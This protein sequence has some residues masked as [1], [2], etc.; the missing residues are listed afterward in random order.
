MRNLAKIGVLGHQLDVADGG[1]VDPGTGRL[2]SIAEMQQALRLVRTGQLEP[3]STA[4]ARTTMPPAPSR[5]RTRGVEPAD[6]GQAVDAGDDDPY[7]WDPEQGSSDADQDAQDDL[8][9][10][11]E[12]NEM[13]GSAR[14]RRGRRVRDEVPA[15]PKARRHGRGSRRAARPDAGAAGTATPRPRSRSAAVRVTR[16]ILGLDRGPDPLAGPPVAD[17]QGFDVPDT[18]EVEPA[19]RRR[20]SAADDF[21]VAAAPRG[22]AAVFWRW[23][24]R[25]LVVVLLAAGVNQLF[26]K[27]LR[28][29][30]ATAIAVA[31]ID[32]AVASQVAARYAADYLSYSPS[33]AGANLPALTADS[34]STASTST[35]L[36]SGA[37][38]VRTDLVQ[39]GQILTVDAAHVLVTE[40]VR[41]HLAIPPVGTA[42]P[43]VVASAP[44]GLP[45]GSAGDPGP[46]PAG[47]T[48][49]G[50]RWITL[51]VPVQATPTGLRVSASGAVFSGEPPMV[52]APIAGANPDSGTTAATQ[53]VASAFFTGY[54]V[55]DV[56]YLIPTGAPVTGLSGA[57]TFVSLAGWTVQTAAA[58]AG[59]S[60]PAA[61][62]AGIGTASVT[63]QLAGTGIQ[64]TQQ[65]AASLS[66][67]SGRWYT[68]ALGPAATFTTNQ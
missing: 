68:A 17:P 28:H 27:P 2:L 39:P 59:S 57:A 33:R 55:S 45:P 34:V 19:A 58:G 30:A 47:W 29:P 63:W 56:S 40:T 5:R 46:V 62:A 16:K 23:T 64:I 10:Q 52:I 38:Y 21:Q 37:G 41:I 4:P 13:L 44:A 15:A 51:T 53:S 18:D 8:D 42:A 60:S 3:D 25:V 32:P 65:Y 48:D 26:I 35:Q 31:V 43:Q 9:E 11:N 24:A 6:T 49:L 61:P 54:G 36:L 12:Q 20:T 67:T 50:E 66:L 22:F 14:P 1:D 7:G